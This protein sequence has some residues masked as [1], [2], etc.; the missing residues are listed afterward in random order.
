MYQE[1]H[2][3]MIERNDRLVLS[4]FPEDTPV[5]VTVPPGVVIRSYHSPRARSSTSRNIPLPF[6]LRFPSRRPSRSRINRRSFPPSPG[7]AWQQ[8]PFV[9]VRR[10]SSSETENFLV[11]FLAGISEAGTVRHEGKPRLPKRGRGF[12]NCSFF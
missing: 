2:K 1:V 7:L 9:F 11:S 4:F 8:N 6:D 3:N 12:R 10:P 5:P